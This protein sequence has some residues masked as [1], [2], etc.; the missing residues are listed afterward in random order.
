MGTRELQLV[1]LK[2]SLLLGVEVVYGHEL[3]GLLPPQSE[4]QWQGRLVPYQKS[5]AS[6][7]PAEENETGMAAPEETKPSKTSNEA[8]A[9][10]EG[11]K[12]GGKSEAYTKTH[13]CNLMEY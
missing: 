9:V 10:L 7:A 5:L 13:K 1:L 6:P 12:H 2:T 3:V 11:L 4:H 8:A